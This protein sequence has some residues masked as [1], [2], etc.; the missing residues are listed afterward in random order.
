MLPILG[1]AIVLLSVLNPLFNPGPL[2]ARQTRHDNCCA[3][4]DA[5]RFRTEGTAPGRNATRLGRV[6]RRSGFDALP[7]IL[8]VLRGDLSLTAPKPARR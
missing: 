2:F 4:I 5:L 7:Q 1:V 6:L 3:P 8:N